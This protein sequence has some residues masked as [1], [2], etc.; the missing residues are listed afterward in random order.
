MISAGFVQWFAE[1]SLAVSALIIAVLFLRRFVA[2]RFG[3]EAAYLLWLAPVIRL[4]M[5]E[6]SVLPHEWRSAAP[7]L[8]TRDGD[9]VYAGAEF[10]FSPA[11]AVATPAD[12]SLIAF[13]VWLFGAVAFLGVQLLA[14]RRFMK[15]VLAASVEPPADIRAE[16]LVI[17]DR[18]G[19]RAAPTIRI[20]DDNIGPLIA[21][22][23]RPTIILPRDF[24][25][26]WTSVERQLAFAHE[27]AH[28]RRGDLWMNLAALGFRAAQWPNPLAHAAFRAF[29]TDQEAACDASVMKRARGDAS[30]AHAYGAAL[31]K[32]AMRG[33]ASPATSLAMS[34]HLKERLMLL[35]SKPKFA[36][37]S[38]RAIAAALVI[39][40]VA[41]SASY[42][43][44]D[45]GARKEKRVSTQVIQVDKG[46]T[47]K[48]AGDDSAAKI[49][50]KVKDGKKTVRTWDRKGKLLSEDVYGAD[51]ETPYDQIVIVDAK[52]EEHAFDL[53]KPAE[54]PLPPEAP[55]PPD[56]PSPLDVLTWSDDEDAM[57]FVFA[58]EPGE[59]GAHPRIIML[60]GDGDHSAHCED[61]G[62][63]ET[64]VDAKSADGKKTVRKEIVCVAGDRAKDP[65]RRAEA[66]RRAIDRM[67]AQ[68][69]REAA[70][71]EKMMAKLRAELA[72][73][74]KEAAKKK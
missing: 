24:A 10:V 26:A 12:I 8:A 49:E 37:A 23:S 60:D 64:E 16:A 5:P 47:L 36:G 20:A 65:E 3:A 21:G 70:H 31:L 35:K 68:A 30:L 51:D 46:E 1:T 17:A 2:D 38:A 27:Y 71:R 22:L 39:A 11:A 34:S 66:L 61:I 14:Q 59:P 54:P 40:G 4:F 62:G 57:S 45:E 25:S 58:G 53:S 6:L 43:Y 63:W 13:A 55:L 74:E 7:M 33:F 9:F 50:V 29:Q 18:S 41:A 52:G 42:S 48:I 67:E 69:A 72:E 32:S 28:L 19:L 44:A 15:K 56:A 73:A